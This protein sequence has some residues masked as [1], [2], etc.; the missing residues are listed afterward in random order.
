[1]IRFKDSREVKCGDYLKD[2]LKKLEKGKP[3]S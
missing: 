3:E 1:V 2:E